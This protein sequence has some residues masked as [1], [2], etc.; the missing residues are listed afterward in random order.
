MRADITNSER[1]EGLA[2]DV[3]SA[4]GNSFGSIPFIALYSGPADSKPVTFGDAVTPAEI[5]KGVAD[6][7]DSP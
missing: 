1:P 5:R 2:F 7:R 4:A 6:L 3:M